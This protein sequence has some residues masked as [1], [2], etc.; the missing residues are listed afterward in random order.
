MSGLSAHRKSLA[1]KK[2]E[3]W[4]ETLGTKESF[5][6]LMGRLISGLSGY[7]GFEVNWRKAFSAF[8][9]KFVFYM[10]GIEMQEVKVFPELIRHNKELRQALRENQLFLE[11]IFLT[12]PA[13]SETQVILSRLIEILRDV[14]DPKSSPRDLRD[15]FLQYLLAR[16]IFRSHPAFNHL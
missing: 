7:L 5:G 8:S 4:N 16:F 10:V 6:M 9:I 12:P 1:L 13:F 2:K 11:P 14:Q 3:Y 15:V